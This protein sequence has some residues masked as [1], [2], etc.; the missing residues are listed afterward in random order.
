MLSKT[1]RKRLRTQ[2]FESKKRNSHD[3]PLLATTYHYLARLDLPEPRAVAANR[4]RPGEAARI[5]WEKRLRRHDIS[6]IK[7]VRYPALDRL[8]STLPDLTQ[9]YCIELVQDLVRPP[10]SGWYPLWGPCV[11]DSGV[12]SKMLLPWSPRPDALTTAY[13]YA[14]IRLRLQGSQACMASVS[15]PITLGR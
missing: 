2:A 3:L 9:D 8:G 14:T 15:S 10:E 12:R 7:E 6:L 4:D 11:D 1:A 13:A 5:G